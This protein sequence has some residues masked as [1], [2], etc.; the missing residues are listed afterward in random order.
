MIFEP[1]NDFL[2]T[3]DLICAALQ[4]S[5]GVHFIRWWLSCQVVNCF[6]RWNVH[7]A[8]RFSFAAAVFSYVVWYL[9]KLWS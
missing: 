1:L 9:A 8:L 3:I 4:Y 5:A 2:C 6:A 7:A